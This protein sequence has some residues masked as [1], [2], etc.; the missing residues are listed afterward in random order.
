M[1]FIQFIFDKIK[2]TKIMK[3][4]SNPTKDFFFLNKKVYEF[5]SRIL[6]DM[7]NGQ[8]TLCHHVHMIPQEY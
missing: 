8:C 1:S 7:H 6:I 2:L 4:S 3:G 5:F